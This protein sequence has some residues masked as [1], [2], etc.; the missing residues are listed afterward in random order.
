MLLRT[1]KLETGR[2]QGE[3]CEA[4]K[5]GRW[6]R[7]IRAWHP[8]KHN[9]PG[10]PIVGWEILYRYMPIGTA[11]DVIMISGSASKHLLRVSRQPNDLCY[12][13]P[14]E[15]ASREDRPRRQQPNV[16]SASQAMSFQ[17]F[18]HWL[19][20]LSNPVQQS[21]VSLTA[22]HDQ[23]EVTCHGGVDVA[24]CLPPKPL[25]CEKRPE[26]SL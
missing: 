1:P 24:F 14:R 2:K 18:G 25:K 11:L 9:Y 16:T 5:R 10:I 3:A 20:A 17:A 26:D 19:I 12:S 21:G 23:C 4:E 22:A 15:A 8:I 7:W 6:C 13:I